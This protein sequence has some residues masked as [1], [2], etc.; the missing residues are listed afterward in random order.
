MTHMV[1]AM[2]SV[3]I[4]DRLYDLSN[5]AKDL[6]NRSIAQQIE[7]WSEIGYYVERLG[8][9]KADLIAAVQGGNPLDEAEKARREAAFAAIR[10]GRMTA[11]APMMFSREMVETARFDSES[12]SLA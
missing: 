2:K 1:I 8:I 5:A 10:A 3:R 9:S 12:V 11:D 7:Y 4:S 6:A